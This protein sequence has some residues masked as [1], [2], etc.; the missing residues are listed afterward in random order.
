MF[1][2]INALLFNQLKI[3]I[4][5]IME[6]KQHHYADAGD[7]STELIQI[8]KQELK[9]LYQKILEYEQLIALYRQEKQQFLQLLAGTK[10]TIDWIH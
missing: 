3:Y 1:F 2:L 8:K 10:T 9:C 6:N 5:Q 4:A 7:D